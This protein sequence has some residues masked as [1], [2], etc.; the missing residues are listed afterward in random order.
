MVS[1]FGPR[2]VERLLTFLEI[3]RQAGRK[4]LVL[5]K[6]AYLLEAMHLA[7]PLRVPDVAHCEDI[8]VYRDPKIAPRAWESALL[9]RYG[10]KVVGAK[11]VR[12]VPTSTPL[13]RLTARSSAW[14]WSG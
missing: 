13:A 5:A 8:M 14:T 6:D 11:E 2:N 12:A 10:S 9:E 7:A 3:A 4:L 1:D